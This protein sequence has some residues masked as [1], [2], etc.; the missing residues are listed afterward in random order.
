MQAVLRSLVLLVAILGGVEG[1]RSQEQ[2]TWLT[3]AALGKQLDQPVGLSWSGL[4][5]RQAMERFAASQRVAILIDRRVDPG[6]LVELSLQNVPLSQALLQIAA[7]K[8]LGFSQF[9]PVAYFG[10]PQAAARLRTLAALRKQDAAAAP[11]DVRN[12]LLAVRAW[13]WDDLAEPRALLAD[14]TT[15]ASIKIEGAD[16]VP[17]DLWAA[18]DLP[19]MT[20]VD[21]LTLLLLQFNLTF[22]I[23]AGSNVVRLVPVSDDPVIERS[24]AAGVPSQLA[25]QVRRNFPKVDVSISGGKLIVRARLEDHELIAAA[26]RGQRPT[27]TKVTKGEQRYTVAFHAKLGDILKK[28]ETTG[29]TFEIDAEQLE[30]AGLSLETIVMVSAKDATLDELLEQVLKPAELAFERQDQTIKIM[31]A[32]GP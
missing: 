1:L 12:R 9:G 19:P 27:R 17:H 20:L 7:S 3:G 14:L 16:K 10:P 26:L 23:D 22:E 29:L 11:K 30:Q 32:M 24:Y 5:L 28:L 21:R 6:Q 8:D 31:P 13:R 15:E 25:S 2:K 4:P 18:A